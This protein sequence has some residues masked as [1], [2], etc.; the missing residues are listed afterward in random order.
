MVSTALPRNVKTHLFKECQL[1]QTW[2][3]N[4]SEGTIYIPTGAVLCDWAKWTPRLISR[5]PEVRNDATGRTQHKHTDQRHQETPSRGT[6]SSPHAT[7]PNSLLN[8]AFSVNINMFPIVWAQ[9][10]LTEVTLLVYYRSMWA[11]CTGCSLLPSTE[12]E[13]L[14][15]EICNH[16]SVLSSC[17]DLSFS[18][19]SSA[20]VK[21]HHPIKESHQR[22]NWNISEFEDWPASLDQFQCLVIRI[23]Q[24][25][26]S[27][28]PWSKHVHG[29]WSSHHHINP[30]NRRMAISFM[31]KKQHVLT[32]DY[33]TCQ[34]TNHFLGC[35]SSSRSSIPRS[36][37]NTWTSDSKGRTYASRVY[38]DNTMLYVRHRQEWY[39]TI[40]CGI[41]A[42]S[43]APLG[44]S[45]LHVKY[46]VSPSWE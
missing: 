42:E 15:T 8:P 7:L 18:T 11:V 37:V 20:K 10:F 21:N 35:G 34:I 46:P 17:I 9:P 13:R 30:T 6:P 24:N 25:T 32:F 38:V 14:H 41:I 27:C 5:A 36:V 33:G 29:G 28:M 23:D 3:K 43:S 4:Y 22:M 31:E 2:S 45:F 19:V 1:N 16:L 39:L 12:S 40:S 44:A 26:A